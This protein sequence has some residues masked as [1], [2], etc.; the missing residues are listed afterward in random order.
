MFGSCD[1]SVKRKF[2]GRMAYMLGVC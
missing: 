1:N 2:L